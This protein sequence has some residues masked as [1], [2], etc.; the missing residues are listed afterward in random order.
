ML[1]IVHLKIKCLWVAFNCKCLSYAF[2]YKCIY[3]LWMHLNAHSNAF[4][5]VNKPGRHFAKK[6]KVINVYQ[7]AVVSK[8][9]QFC[10]SHFTC[11]SEKTL[12]AF[13]SSC[14][15]SIAEEDLFF[16]LIKH[17]M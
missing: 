17:C 9:G 6:Y 8:L 14:L 16:F 1:L 7:N 3:N 13:N 15:V 10:S 5:F 2:K 11:I 4:A 12:K